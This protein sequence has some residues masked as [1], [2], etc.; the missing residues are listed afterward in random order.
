[1]LGRG[2]K[3][4][5]HGESGSPAKRRNNF[6]SLLDFRR[7]DQSDVEPSDYKVDNC[8]EETESLLSDGFG[9]RG[10]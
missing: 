7:G 9:Q 6:K 5:E 4:Y 3:R 10:K 1:M 8:P 2:R